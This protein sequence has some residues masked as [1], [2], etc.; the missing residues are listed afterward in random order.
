MLQKSLPM[1]KGGI[2]PIWNILMSFMIYDF[3]ILF[4]YFASQ[5]GV[6]FPVSFNL[7]HWQEEHKAH[8]Q[9]VSVLPLRITQV[10]TGFHDTKRKETA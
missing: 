2:H 6:L 5:I 1:L 9:C 8:F 7:R 10:I 3:V 4:F